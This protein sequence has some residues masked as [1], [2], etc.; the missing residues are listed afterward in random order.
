MRLVG[1]L[2]D[3][4]PPAFAPRIAY[5]TKYLNRFGW[6]AVVFTE[7]VV[8]HQIFD[9]FEEV[10]PTIRVPLRGHGR[11]KRLTQVIAEVLWEYKERCFTKAIE[12][13][14]GE[15]PEMRPDILLCFTYRKFP[16][17]TASVLSH[18]W[19]IPWV[20]DCRDIIEQYSPGDWLPKR[21]CLGS[22]PLTWVEKLLAQRYIHLRNRYLRLASCVSTISCWHKQ[23]LEKVLD[24]PVELIY[25]GFADELFY[26]RMSEQVTFVIR[27]TGRILSLEMRDP[28]LLFE[29]L[30]RPP[31]SEL[32]ITVELYTDTYSQALLK[33]MIKEWGLCD[34]VLL[35]DMVSSQCVPNLLRSSAIILL[36]GNAEGEGRPQGMVS[37]KLFEALALERPLLL[38]PMVEG[39]TVDILQ[40][41]GC[42][43]AANRVDEISAYILD[44][45]HMWLNHGYTMVQTPNRDKIA[46]YS[47]LGQ[48]K[49]FTKIL[50]SLIT[51]S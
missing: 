32:P 15:H 36:L 46:Q 3:L 29:A 33:P 14:V 37:T 23:L 48:A 4:Y 30:S 41:S 22:I 17:R 21:L 47:R 51:T 18:R 11:V 1:V 5:L 20:G 40:S 45:Y 50:N 35:C 13:Y 28:S 2:T 16:L 39:E 24:R 19:N 12:Q 44:Q 31:L 38:L 25:N 9:D 26:P 42:G 6:K 43:I 27:Y 8:E 10:C 7:L 49:Q 34:R